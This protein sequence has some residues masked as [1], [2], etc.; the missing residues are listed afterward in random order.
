MKL[1]MMTALNKGGFLI[2]VCNISFTAL[3]FKITPEFEHELH[4]NSRFL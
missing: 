1:N 4:K 2:P 3:F